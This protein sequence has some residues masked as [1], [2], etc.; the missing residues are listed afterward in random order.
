MTGAVGNNDECVNNDP[1]ADDDDLDFAL[2]HSLYERQ[3][4]MQ[5][6]NAERLSRLWL[7]GLSCKTLGH[8]SGESDEAWIEFL[9][10]EGPIFAE[11]YEMNVKIVGAGGFAVPFPGHFRGQPCIVKVEN[12]ELVGDEYR[13]NLV[14]AGLFEVLLK[15]SQ[16]QEHPNIVSYYDFLEGPLNY[17]V[18]MEQLQGSDLFDQF[19]KDYPVKEEYIRELMLQVLSSLQHIHDVV[20]LVHRDVKLENFR[21]AESSATSE[22]KLLDFGFARRKHAPYEDNISGTLLYLAPEVLATD[23]PEERRRFGTAADVWAAGV[24]FYVLLC[25]REPFKEPEVWQ[26]SR[27]GGPNLV[28]K[29]MRNMALN[30]WSKD[31]KDLL[32]KL[33][34][35]NP[36]SR[37]TAAQALLHPWFGSKKLTLATSPVPSQIYRLAGE[38]SKRSTV[39]KGQRLDSVAGRSSRRARLGAVKASSAKSRSLSAGSPRLRSQRSIQFDL[40]SE[41]LQHEDTANMQEPLLYQP[42]HSSISLGSDDDHLFQFTD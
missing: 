30:H 1:D 36:S 34:T 42:Q 23:L 6:A 38:M 27:G 40:P 3:V 37:I 28:A 24:L 35:L 11:L 17:Y 26:L 29:C 39:F 2:G 19:M 14:E 13:Q 10:D 9:P 15:M 18:V 12:K 21:Y 5:I 41:E 4:N 25:G 33:L 8:A 16:E 32:E 20:G 31:A 7:R 22:L